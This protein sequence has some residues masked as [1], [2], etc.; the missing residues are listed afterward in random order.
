[1]CPLTPPISARRSLKCWNVG[2]LKFW[3][4]TSAM[5]IKRSSETA[6]KN[7]CRAEGC[8][9]HDMLPLIVVTLFSACGISR[10]LNAQLFL[11]QTPD[12]SLLCTLWLHEK[13][14]N[15]PLGF[16]RSS[17]GWA[18]ARVIEKQCGPLICGVK[19]ISSLWVARIAQV[20][21]ANQRSYLWK[22]VAFCEHLI[23]LPVL[24][25]V[26]FGHD[27]GSHTERLM[28]TRSG[29]WAL[30]LF[31]SL[32]LAISGHKWHSFIATSESIKTG[33]QGVVCR[34]LK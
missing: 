21:R 1:M 34:A 22:V 16:S 32:Q 17:K 4:C 25:F 28:A 11:C 29:E 14:Y 10:H 33:G 9:W 23:N 27:V 6:H 18:S 5:F 24:S 30:I 8:F 31:A 2:G 19:A 12:P 20:T 3:F 26:C 7:I 15:T 13:C